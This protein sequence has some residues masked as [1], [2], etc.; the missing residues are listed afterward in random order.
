MDFFFPLEKQSFD[1]IHDE[2]KNNEN[3]C[4]IFEYSTSFPTSA[5]LWMR[6]MLSYEFF[7]RIYKTIYDIEIY[8]RIY[9]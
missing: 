5:S 1:S 2:D 3:H 7:K 6:N 8:K 9:L 4:S